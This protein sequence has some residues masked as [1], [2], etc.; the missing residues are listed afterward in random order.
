MA[1][2][3]CHWKWAMDHATLLSPPFPPAASQSAERIGVMWCGV[4]LALIQDFFDTRLIILTPA[5]HVVHVTNIR[6]VCASQTTGANSM[7]TCLYAIQWYSSTCMCP[8]CRSLTCQVL[9]YL[10][11]TGMNQKA[12]YRDWWQWSVNG[13]G[14]GGNGVSTCIYTCM[15]SAHPPNA[16]C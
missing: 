14:I 3:Y 11:T 15:R 12:I 16:M 8:D 2:E 6:Y 13:I 9:D 10:P 1:I 7:S 5:P 4:E